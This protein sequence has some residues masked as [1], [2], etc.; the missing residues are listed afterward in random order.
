VC[1]QL[2]KLR[3]RGKRQRLTHKDQRGARVSVQKS[4]AGGNGHS[5]TNISAHGIDS[6][7]DHRE[8]GAV[9]N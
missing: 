8:T 6:D 7:P 1:L 4:Q 5:G 3:V 9:M 2:G